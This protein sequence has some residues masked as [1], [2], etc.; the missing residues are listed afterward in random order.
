MAG[1]GTRLRPQTLTTPKPLIEIAGAT[2][3]Q[4]IV[5]LVVRESTI[6]INYVGFILEGG[7]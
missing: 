3:I 4:R 1:R 2:I 5:D 6:K 7:C